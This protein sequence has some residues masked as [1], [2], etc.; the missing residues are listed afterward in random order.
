V[1]CPLAWCENAKLEGYITALENRYSSMKDISASFN[2]ETFLG[3][4]NRIE[5]AE[6][7]V[8]IKKGGKMLWDYI[9]P[10]PQKIILDGEN[11]W[12]YLPE[13]K[14]AVKN[15]FTS[16]SSHIIADLFYGKVAIKK[17]FNV[18]FL[19]TN[20]QDNSTNIILELLPKEYTPTI[21]RLLLE[22]D[23]VSSL[24]TE[25]VLEDEMGTKTTLMFS[26]IKV[27]KGIEDSCFT[28]IPPPGVEIFSPPK[29]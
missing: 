25:T 3:I 22:I 19:N 26:E 16:F 2:Q 14:Q 24:I 6:G 28:F 27:D 4:A 8:Y 10:T 20:S 1:F 21:K 7:K 13:E 11:L 18:S 15:T 9:Q 23:P 29:F 12:V 17:S 5:K